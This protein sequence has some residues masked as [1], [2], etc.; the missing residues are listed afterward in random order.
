V[1]AGNDKT[2]IDSSNDDLVY[3]CSYD[4]DNILCV[5]SVNDN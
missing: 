2:N 1:A 5:A 3:P 4:L